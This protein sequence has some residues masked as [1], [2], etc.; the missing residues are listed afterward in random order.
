M[1]SRQTCSRMPD[2]PMRLSV[3]RSGDS[4]SVRPM[5]LSDISNDINDWFSGSG[6]LADIVVSSRIRLARNL[7]GYKFL[8]S[9]SDTEKANI[10]K[11]LKA[12][13]TS[14]DLGDDVFYVSVD[15][16]PTLNRNPAIS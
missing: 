2:V 5:K 16:A 12:V 9:C 3:T 14:L 4:I 6:P 8:N 13:L 10:L 1:R 7:A 11:R 15:E